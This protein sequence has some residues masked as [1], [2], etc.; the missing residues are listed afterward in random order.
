MGL[1]PCVSHFIYTPTHTQPTHTYVERER[2]EKR[3]G[4]GERKKKKESL[5]R[6]QTQAKEVIRSSIKLKER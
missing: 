3:R 5:E 4:R 6:V 1:F 2:E